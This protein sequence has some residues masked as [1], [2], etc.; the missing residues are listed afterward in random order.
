V[1]RAPNGGSDVANGESDVANGES[2]VANGGA[3]K[4][5][6]RQSIQNIIT[7]III[8]IVSSAVLGYLSCPSG[9]GRMRYFSLR[10]NE[11]EGPENFTLASLAVL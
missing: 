5:V 6:D 7:I 11:F 1:R 2:D 9:T 10:G 4:L 8:G 3:H